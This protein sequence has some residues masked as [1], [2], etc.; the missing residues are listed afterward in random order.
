MQ[1]AGKLA[2]SLAANLGLAGFWGRMRACASA[3]NLFLYR[4][5]ASF[6]LG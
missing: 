4:S 3:F 5:S 1:K 2:A 6:V